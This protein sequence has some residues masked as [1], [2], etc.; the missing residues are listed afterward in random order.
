MFCIPLQ[1]ID[2]T[3]NPQVF[4]NS[5]VLWTVCLFPVRFDPYSGSF[6]ELESLCAKMRIILCLSSQNPCGMREV[7]RLLC[8]ERMFQQ[9]ESMMLFWG[10]HMRTA[11]PV[12]RGPLESCNTQD[13]LRR[14]SS[15]VHL[16]WRWESNREIGGEHSRTTAS[17]CWCWWWGNNGYHCPSGLYSH[18]HSQELKPTEQTGLDLGS[19]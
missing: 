14:L 3:D 11:T 18:V 2:S 6:S 10:L 15:D 13:S 16:L 19:Y 7:G 4:S 12:F 5:L 9:E 1:K 8:R 17:V